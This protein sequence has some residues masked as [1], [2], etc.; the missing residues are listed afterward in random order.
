MFCKKIAAVPRGRRDAA[1]EKLRRKEK[2][3]RGTNK[4]KAPLRMIKKVNRRQPY[5]MIFCTPTGNFAET[6]RQKG[7]RKAKIPRTS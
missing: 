1:I 3:E 2:T 7:G 5:K 6:H 4:D